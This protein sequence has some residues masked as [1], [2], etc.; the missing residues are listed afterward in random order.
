MLLEYSDRKP[1]EI[2]RLGYYSV[3][4]MLER[5]HSGTNLEPKETEFFKANIEKEDICKA[6]NLILEEDDSKI[7]RP[8][9]HV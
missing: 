1:Y 8:L 6:I 7:Q 3:N 9:A 5:I 2:Q 4:C